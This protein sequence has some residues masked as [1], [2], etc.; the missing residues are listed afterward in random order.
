MLRLPEDLLQSD[1][2]DAASIDQIP[3]QVSSPYRGQLIAVPYQ[4]DTAVQLQRPKQMLKQQHIHHG[5]FV[6]HKHLAV[7]WILFIVLEGE[8]FVAV[9]LHL[10]QAVNGLCL[11]AG[12]I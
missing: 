2:R 1:Y 10:Q 8:P 4:N 7:Q 6:H 12:Q 11:I 3:Q 5:H 9:K